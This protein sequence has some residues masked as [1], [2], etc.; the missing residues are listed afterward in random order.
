MK[1]TEHFWLD[2]TQAELDFV[3]ILVDED[4]KLFLD[5]WAIRQWWDDFSIECHNTIVNFF[6]KLVNEINDWNEIKALEMLNRLHEPSET[7]LWF[8]KS[9]TSGSWIWK[10]KAKDI[11]DKLRESEA[12]KTWFLTNIED[13]ALMIE[14]ISEDNISDIVTNIIKIHLIKYTKNQCNLLW[15]ELRNIPTWYFW[16]TEKEKWVSAREDMLAIGNKKIILVPKIFVRKSL[17][18]SYDDY[19]NID[20]LEFEQRYH[21]DACTSLCITLKD[22]SLKMPP[23]KILKEEHKKKYKKNWKAIVYEITK[24]YPKILENYKRKKSELFI[25]ITNESIDKDYDVKE[26]IENLINRLKSI[27]PWKETAKDY[28]NIITSILEV[29]FY[30]QLYNPTKQE[31]VNSWRKIIDISFLN[32]DNSWFFL[33][34][35]KVHIPCRKIFFECKNYSN[36]VSNP[37]FDQMNWRFSNHVSQVW[38]IVCREI[39]NKQLFIERAKD[40]VRDKGHFI[41]GLDDN[42]L[43]ELLNFKLEWRTDK[44]NESLDFKLNKIL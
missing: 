39:R 13:T 15:I 37:E 14:W 25:P 18:I 36:E 32:I 1:L 38:F 20:V 23:K 27:S 7:H 30:P 43:I 21:L 24:Q 19:Y 31:R 17:E 40:F 33:N 41:I 4:V 3:D 42:D 2:K 16:S 9:N 6:E 12:V 22:W 29:V 5:P 34:L 28:E 26:D 11:Y 10:F 35:A 44:I 8:S